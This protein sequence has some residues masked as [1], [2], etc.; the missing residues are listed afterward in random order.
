M[1]HV[2][3]WPADH[4]AHYQHLALKPASESPQAIA[5]AA[6]QGTNPAP[7]YADLAP[8]PNE[9]ALASPGQLATPQ[10]LPADMRQFVTNVVNSG[11][12]TGL[13][14]QAILKHQF[15]LAFWLIAPPRPSQQTVPASLKYRIPYASAAFM[16]L[17]H[18]IYSPLLQLRL[19]NGDD[20]Y[21]AVAP[22]FGLHVAD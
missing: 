15:D 22:G 3:G 6:M 20:E 2:N 11:V 16:E 10:E 5:L 12:S 19:G 8:L 9:P 1:A 21:H 18:R 13:K 17:D 14:T 4:P 7:T